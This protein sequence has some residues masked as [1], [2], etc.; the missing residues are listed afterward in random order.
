M[1]S[2]DQAGAPVGEIAHRLLFAC[3]FA[4]KIDN[5]RV[6]TG[7][8]RAGR[9]LALD[10]GKRVVERVH[11]DPAH[12]VDHQSPLAVLGVDQR[13]AAAG[14]ALRKIER[15]NEARRAL[16]EDQ[17]FAL[18]PRVV[19][20]RDRI[21]AGIDQ[22]IVDDLGDAEAAGGVLAVDDDEIELPIGNEWGSRSMT[23]VRPERPTMS[24][25]K[26]I[27]I[28]YFVSRKSMTS[29]SVSTKSRRASRSVAGTEAISWAAKAMPI[30]M[31][32]FFVRS[33]LMVMS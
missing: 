2:D 32:F 29:R 28:R 17:R 12:G 24:P 26:R 21:R 15:S 16:D 9:Q 3:R 23:M 19:A 30:A 22:L 5:D 6:R 13:R 11:E 33:A 27:R 1:G 31:A 7:I 18:I 8:E 25:I 14:R 10:C 20:E 4:V